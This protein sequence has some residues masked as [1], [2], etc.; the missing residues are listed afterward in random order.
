MET[1]DGNGYVQREKDGTISYARLIKTRGPES[2][3]KQPV[4]AEQASWT[5]ETKRVVFD[6]FRFVYED[7]SLAAPSRIVVSNTTL[8]G[9]NF[10]NWK[11]RAAKRRSKPRS[12]TKGP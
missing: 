10:S 4:K 7:R 8:R 5:V 1:R 3:A 6:R 9:E 2:A 11:S 12:T